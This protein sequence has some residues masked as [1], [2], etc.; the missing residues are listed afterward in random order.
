MGEDRSCSSPRQKQSGPKKQ[1]T[2][3]ISAA[4]S[5]IAVLLTRQL[6]ER[7]DNVVAGDP[8]SAYEDQNTCLADLKDMISELRH[9]ADINANF[10]ILSYDP[11]YG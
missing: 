8:Y 10:K 2:W 3:F 11:R 6:L 5:P 4:H 9:Q 7:G 1:L